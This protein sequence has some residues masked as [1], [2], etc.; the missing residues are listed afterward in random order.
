MTGESYLIELN[1]LF[2]KCQKMSSSFSAASDKY[3][4][5]I[6]GYRTSQK[7][8][9]NQHSQVAQEGRKFQCPECEFRTINK[10]ILMTHQK[11]VHMGLKFQCP[12]CDYE[13]NT[14]GNVVGG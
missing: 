6:C 9:F 14:K 8:H 13:A 7:T 1:Q 12:E 11:S 3:T 2:Q 5:Q 10:S 4:C